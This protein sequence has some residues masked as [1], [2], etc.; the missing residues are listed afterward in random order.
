MAAT[1]IIGQPDEATGSCLAPDGATASTLRFPS[2]AA[3]DPDGNLWVADYGNSR[4]LKYQPP[5]T[6]GMAASVALGQ[7]TTNSTGGSYD[8]NHAN[9]GVGP[10]GAY[11]DPTAS[12][13]C[14]PSRVAFDSTGNLWVV[15]QGNYRVL[16]YPPA[17]Q[18]QGG[19][20]T[21]VIGQTD[22]ISALS[23]STAAALGSPWDLGFDRF[24]NL[25]VSDITNNRVL[26]YQAPFLNGMDASAALGQTDL[27]SNGFGT[28]A[29]K[30]H[31]PYGLSFDNVGNLLV[32]D[33]ANNRTLIFSQL[34]QDTG[35]SATNALG[36][37]DLVS[38]TANQGG[39]PSELTEDNPFGVLEFRL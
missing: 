19:A 27:V 26:K 35:G 33:S 17:Q 25:W 38:G 10:I 6:N 22:F 39:S 12:T 21:L 3:M 2:G 37:R 13:L 30:L 32:T 15:D 7:T 20:A 9:G 14:F 16:M 23:G 28:S 34:E 4:V 5:F 36:Q 31:Y 1:T 29:S 8:C 18:M 24:E 11:P